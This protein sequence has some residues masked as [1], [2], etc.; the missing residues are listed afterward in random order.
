MKQFI[1]IL[2]I[3]FTLGIIEAQAQNP[4]VRIKLGFRERSVVID[5]SFDNNAQRI[6]EIV[7]LLEEIR[8]DSTA[9]VVEVQFCG[10]ASPEDSY[11]LN[12]RLARERLK[13]LERIV[14][15]QIS[16]P[17][18]IIVRDD[19]YIPWHE[20]KA[21][22]EASEISHKREIMS[23]ID[24]KPR[25]V[26]HHREG[27]HVD[28]RVEK[29][30]KLDEGRIWERMDQEFFSQL[31]NAFA[32]IIT[33]RMNI[34]KVEGTPELVN[35]YIEPK[36]SE[37]E[38]QKPFEIEKTP[39]EWTPHLYIK[40]NALALAMGVSNIAVEVDITKH[41]SFTLPIYYSAWNYFTSDLKFRTFAVQPEVRYWFSKKNDG[42]F[43]GAHYGFAYYNVAWGGKWRIQDHRRETP[44]MGSGV[45]VGY[46][47]PLGAS[48]RWKLEF[49][50]GG[51]VYDLHY[52]KFSNEPNGELVKSERKTFFGVDNAAV[53]LAYTFD[54]K[55]GGK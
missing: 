49:S 24:E 27:E 35:I 46:R 55:K 15:S 18:S 41:L 52:D 38:Y 45:S 16:I 36:E 44:T 26:A 30:K 17:D 25:L 4:E 43:T 50:V 33:C 39:V 42:W 19:S 47:K 20:L 37:I 1:R 12:K 21:A 23:I 31:R 5:P 54:L 29:L 53:T 9:E 28:N 6:K 7:A 8:N 14:R 3:I 10:A 32:I 11:Q 51:G 40:T 22:V 34:P 13:A 2:L 48:K